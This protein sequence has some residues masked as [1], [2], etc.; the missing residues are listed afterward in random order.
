MDNG[1][2]P[3]APRRIIPA[4]LRIDPAAALVWRSPSTLQI[5]VDPPLAVLRDLL[6]TAERI[7]TALV[8]GTDPAS[9]AALA[10]DRALEPAELHRILAAVEPALAPVPPPPAVPALVEGPP[11]LVAGLGVAEGLLA[12]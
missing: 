6:P 3:T 9:L 2:T 7:V 12:R 10:V 5:G 1:R 4:V 8:A 11:D